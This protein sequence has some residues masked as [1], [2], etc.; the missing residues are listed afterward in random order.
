MIFGDV[1]GIIAH[2]AFGPVAGVLV[3]F[4]EM[5]LRLPVRSFESGIIGMAANFCSRWH[6]GFSGGLVYQYREDE[7]KGG[8][9]TCDR[10]GRC[11]PGHVSGKLLYFLPLWG[12]PT[13]GIISHDG[14][15]RV[16]FYMANLLFLPPFTF[17]VYKGGQK[18]ARRSRIKTGEEKINDEQSLVNCDS[19][20]AVI[21]FEG[22]ISVKIGLIGLPNPQ[23]KTTFF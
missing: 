7:A 13:E 14:Y 21:N 16:S 19:I 1:P 11:F 15:G 2:F 4:I 5:Y 9:G 12:F 6:D 8:L 18:C 22:E 10:V 20:E 23:G 17:F 3:Q